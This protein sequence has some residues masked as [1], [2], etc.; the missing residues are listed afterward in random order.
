MR[1]IRK[2]NSEFM[3]TTADLMEFVFGS[4]RSNLSAVVPMLMDIQAGRCFYCT[5]TLNKSSIHVDH[6]IA[7]SRY[8]MDL[9]HN[10]VLAHHTCNSA[11]AD[12]IAAF[13]HL[14]SW[15]DRS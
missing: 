3:G 8:P 5:G 15:V 14:H 7:W 1:Y 6:F 4:E 2:Q 11:K 12:H 13:E 10:F 9:G